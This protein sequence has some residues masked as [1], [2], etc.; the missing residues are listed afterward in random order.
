MLLRNNE[1]KI[2]K[3]NKRLLDTFVI[4]RIIDCINYLIQK[5]MW[6]CEYYRGG[7]VLR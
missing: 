4:Q 2:D 1:M 5:Y 3:L 7:D 6:Y